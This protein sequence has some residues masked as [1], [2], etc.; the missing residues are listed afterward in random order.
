ME[1]GTMD[2][3]GRPALSATAFFCLFFPYFIFV[4]RKSPYVVLIPG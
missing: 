1:E 2:V 3:G 4:L